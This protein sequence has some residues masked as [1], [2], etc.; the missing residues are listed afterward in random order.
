MMTDR[1]FIQSPGE[2]CFESSGQ[3][4]RASFQMVL[5][6]KPSGVSGLQTA[7]LEMKSSWE[8][9]T[10]WCKRIIVAAVDVADV[11]IS[12]EIHHKE[13]WRNGWLQKIYFKDLL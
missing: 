12:V 2:Y 11:E 1:C 5:C 7:A 4:T 9:I 13:V 3:F 10:N 6:N 8:K